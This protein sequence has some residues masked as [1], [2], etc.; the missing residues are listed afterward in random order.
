[1]HDEIAI[2]RD[3]Y[4]KTADQYDD[5]HINSDVEHDFALAFMLSMI[6]FLSI[7]SMLD[8][9]SGTGRALL[10]AKKASQNLKVLGIEPSSELRKVGYTKGL[11]QNE[12]IDGD[13]QKLDFSDGAFDLVCAF[14]ALHHIPEPSKAVS[15]MLRVARKAIFISDS[16][17]F[18]QGG[19]VSRIV[20]QTLRSLGLWKVVDSVK[21]RG[22]GYMISEGD[23]LAYSYS[24]FND[25]SEISRRCKSVHLLNT[26][27]AGINLY[28]SASHIAVLGIK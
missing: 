17:N 18:G 23:G 2:Q 21:T 28:R 27:P 3:Y 26:R 19:F 8:I 5:M 16:N 15:E 6:E 10:R 25:Y 24:V 1:M 9:G 20:K 13:A 4:R 11:S 22:R 14:A 12:L 7:G